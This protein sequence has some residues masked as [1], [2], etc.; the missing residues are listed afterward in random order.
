ME[1]EF[2]K[3]IFKLEM[4]LSDYFTPKLGV[5]FD[6]MQRCGEISLIMSKLCSLP[7]VRV[8]VNIGVDKGRS[9]ISQALALKEREPK[10]AGLIYAVDN[11]KEDFFYEGVN[12]VKGLK[13][14]LEDFSEILANGDLNPK[15][16][17]S[18]VLELKKNLIDLYFK[19]A[20]GVRQSFYFFNRQEIYDYVIKEASRLF[21]SD[22]SEVVKKVVLGS[23]DFFANFNSLINGKYADLILIDGDHSYDQC[24]KDIVNSME[25]V[26][27]GGYIVVHDYCRDGDHDGV[28]KA[29]DETINC[30]DRFCLEKDFSWSEATLLTF[31]RT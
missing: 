18:A 7:S 12:F 19:N 30:D 11:F 16:K 14:V 17:E 26:A 3:R 8:V 24:R 21:V 1:S 4:M 31:R 20:C 5:R 9:L 25:F 27:P 6:R 23:D 2:I 15:E 13:S 22:L 10:V 29:V 28:V